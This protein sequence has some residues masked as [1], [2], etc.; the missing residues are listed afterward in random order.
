MRFSSGAL[1]GRDAARPDQC[2]ARNDGVTGDQDGVVAV[3]QRGIHIISEHTDSDFAAVGRIRIEGLE[4]GGG[5]VAPDHGADAEV[6]GGGDSV[7]FTLVQVR[8]FVLEH[9]TEGFG[10]GNGSHGLL[11]VGE[12]L[13]GGHHRAVLWAG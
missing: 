5:R 12:F 13:G 3:D 4:F 11:L 10:L 8:R 1:R 6:L 2:A 7:G 9:V